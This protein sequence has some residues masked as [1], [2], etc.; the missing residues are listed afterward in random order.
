MAESDLESKNLREEFQSK[1]FTASSRKLCD[2]ISQEDTEL[3]RI[4]EQQYQAIENDDDGMTNELRSLQDA[5]EI[6]RREVENAMMTEEDDFAPL[7]P[8]LQDEN[9]EEM[10]SDMEIPSICWTSPASTISLLNKS[11]PE[12]IDIS[13]NLDLSLCATSD[14]ASTTLS[15]RTPTRCYDNAEIRKNMKT[16]KKIRGAYKK[17]TKTMPYGRSKYSESSD[18]MEDYV[19]KTSSIHQPH[20]SHLRTTRR[21]KK[22]T[23]EAKSLLKPNKSDIAS[24]QNGN[25]ILSFQPSQR[26]QN[27][28]EKSLSQVAALFVQMLLG[29]EFVFSFSG[30]ISLIARLAFGR[31]EYTV[32][33]FFTKTSSSNDCELYTRTYEGSISVFLSVTILIASFYEHISTPFFWGMIVLIPFLFTMLEMK[34]PHRIDETIIAFCALSIRLFVDYYVSR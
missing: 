13:R 8:P 31:H 3:T 12:L 22:R 24:Y 17:K 32:N 9:V 21:K 27:V 25:S 6:V 7:L 20:S 33:V 4:L 5:E 15:D 2:I 26:T 16:R 18:S 34:L 23:A 19:L 29:E 14:A 1:E 30:I 11:S 10:I 28:Q